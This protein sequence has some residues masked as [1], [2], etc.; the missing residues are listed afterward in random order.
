MATVRIFLP[1]YRRPR[2]LPRAVASLRAQT[3]TDW[4][5]ELHNDDPADPVPAQLVAQCA[6]ARITLVRHAR[7]LG[8]TA[9]FNQFFRATP[10]PFYSMLEDDNWWEPA[11]LQTLLD[12]ARVHPA[13]TVFWANMRIWEELPD[14]TWRDT[15]R[16]VWPATPGEAVRL[17][18]WGQP[19]QICG[20]LHSHG[21]ALF[22]SRPWDNF[23]TPAVPIAVTE[24]FR[25]RCLPHP[26]ALVP[27]PLANFS[28]TRETA[29]SR[30]AAEW[31]ET[32]AMLAAT[33]FKACPW[34]REKIAAIWDEARAQTPPA[35]TNLILAALADPDCRRLLRHARWRDWWVVL[36]GFIRRPD[37]YFRVRASRQ[38]RADWWQFLAEHTAGRWQ[39]T[40]RS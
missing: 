32:Q 16:L 14:A 24:P 12:A 25:E 40:T 35:T 8:G 18:P 3:F 2:L 17:M 20:A 21:A 26:L 34:P 5:C 30:D 1:T 31:A 37:L 19:A 6:D 23:A 10:E 7:N 13:V 22:R 29:R 28:L 36:R 33:F 11:F 9:T 38:T 4:V 39:E 15:G 27:Q